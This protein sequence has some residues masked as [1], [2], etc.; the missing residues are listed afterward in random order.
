M[1]FSGSR[2]S[3]PESQTNRYFFL[4]LLINKIILN[5]VT[6]VGTKKGRTTYFFPPPLLLLLL[7]PRSVIRDLGWI[8]IRIR[9]G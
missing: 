4:I 1:F 7:D 8:N 2:I 5:F 3:D 6:F 9:E